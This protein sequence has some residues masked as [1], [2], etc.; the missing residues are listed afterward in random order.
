MISSP[1][2]GKD[3]RPP[4]L[5][6]PKNRSDE[7]SSRIVRRTGGHRRS[8]AGLLG[9]PAAKNLLRAIKQHV[10]INAEIPTDQRDND[11]YAD[12]KPTGTARHAARC[13]GFAIIFNISA[14]AE[15]I[16][17]HG[18][19]PAIRSAENHAFNTIRTVQI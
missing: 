5:G 7:L 13:A 3:F 2:C 1:G 15:I 4:V 14:A 10:W 19:I 11:H 6:V 16:D 8:R 9:G 17:S 18:S 12:A